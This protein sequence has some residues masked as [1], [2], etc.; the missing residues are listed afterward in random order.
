ML[1]ALVVLA[2]GSAVAGKIPIPHFVAPVLRVA[3]PEGHVSW[4]PYAASAAAILGIAVAYYLYVVAR[5]TQ[6][7]LAASFVPVRGVLEAKYYF[8]DVFNGFASKVVVNGSDGLLWKQVD[9]RWIDGFVNMTGQVTD[10][11][12]RVLRFVQMGFVRGYALVILGGAAA[13]LGY[14]LWLR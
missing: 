1:S 4:V 6:Q 13:L 7:S 10:S 3:A 12:A 9:A 5:A 2:I 11:V 8:D 14:M